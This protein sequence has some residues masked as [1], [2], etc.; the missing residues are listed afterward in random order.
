MH[1]KAVGIV[2]ADTM[3]QDGTIGVRWKKLSEDKLIEI[4]PEKFKNNVFNNTLYEEFN[5]DIIDFV[6][7]Q[8]IKGER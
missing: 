2:T 6:I 3:G 1:I 7:S 5:S 4:T 8:I